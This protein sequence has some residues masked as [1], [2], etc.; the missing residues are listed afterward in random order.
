MVAPP[1][2]LPAPNLFGL[3]LDNLDGPDRFIVQALTHLPFATAGEIAAVYSRSVNGIHARLP[4]LQDAGFLESVP[5]TVGRR[6]AVRWWVSPRNTFGPYAGRSLHHP[7]GLLARLVDNLPMVG[8]VYSLLADICAAAPRRSLLQF[9]WYRRAPFDAA[10]L[11]DDCWVVFNWSGLWHDQGRITDRMVKLPEGFPGGRLPGSLWPARTVWFALDQWQAHLVSRAAA[12]LDRTDETVIVGP[13]GLLSGSFQYMTARG[14]SLP[15]LPATWLDDADIAALLPQSISA[16]PEGPLLHRVMGLVEQWPG[17]GYRPLRLMTR[18]SGRRLSAALQFLLER[19]L[20]LKPES[21]SHYLPHQS[22]LAHAARRD[23]VWSGRP[24]RRF[25]AANLDGYYTG[26]IAD[27]ERGLIALMARFA[28]AGLPT[29]AGWRGILNM[30]TRGQFSPD[31]FVHLTSGPFGPGWHCVEYERRAASPSTVDKKLSPFRA[32]PVHER[33]P[34]LVVC[35]ARA[36]PLFAQAAGDLPLLTATLEE[37]RSGPLVGV[38]N[39][40]WR[41]HGAPV[42]SLY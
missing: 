10:A 40:V 27:H 11:F 2:T 32:L 24:A 37:V 3:A 13:D 22:W 21:G 6:T 28:E 39:T 1:D 20:L 41:R 14:D 25:S 18:V 4:R 8:M 30:G 26:R 35:R 16:A 9:Q 7:S 12:S 29:A 19:R 17:I 38:G 36:A 34:M 23:R 15:P 42:S 33:Y 31:G 5:L